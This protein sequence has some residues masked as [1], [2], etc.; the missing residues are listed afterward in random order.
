MQ[1]HVLQLIKGLDI[2]DHSG[3][4]D[5]YGL[6]LTKALKRIGVQVS[7]A[8]L[9][10]YDTD[11]EQENLV[12]LNELSI[13]V[14]FIEGKHTLAKIRSSQLA[15][16]CIKNE[17]N[18]LNSHFPV[19]TLASIWTRKFR[20]KGKITRTAH[21]DK[22]W[23]NGGLAWLFRQ[24]FTKYVF[25]LKT[26]L[27]VGVSRNIVNT[28]NGYP[29]T[30][31]SK[32]KATVIH[33]GILQNWFE[34]APNKKYPDDSVKVIG[35]IGLLTGRKGYQYLIAALPKVLE[36]YPESEL[37]IAGEGSFRPVL[38]QQIH[39]LGLQDKVRLV[40]RQTDI[41]YWFEQM[42]LFVLPSLIEGL[43][44]VVI[45]SMARGV[46]VIA[47]DIPGNNELVTDGQTGWLVRPR[48]SKD[49]SSK[50]LRAFSDSVLYKKISAQAF[51][52]A[53]EL[54]IENAAKKY[55]ALYRQLF[56]D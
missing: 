31:W 4:S 33:N 20:Y 29:G 18:V 42:D 21:I 43:P 27:Q 19:G 49:L 22:E 53:R 28:I 46:P 10:S 37:I 52:W 14:I 15:S 40:G 23:G 36:K 30:K 44:T 51:D 6:E 55:A 3:G 50:I 17:I 12:A 48:S 11:I 39:K 2:G 13:P 26:D 16:Y 7:L 56:K 8:C 9:N 47:S 54:T 5:K 1:I 35:A 41:R 24:V 32:R 25:P 34:P 45:E 38:E